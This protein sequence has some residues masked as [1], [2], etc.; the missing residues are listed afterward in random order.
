[1]EVV[2]ETPYV[3]FPFDSTV[4]PTAPALTIVVKGTFELRSGDPAVALPKAKQAPIASD[5]TYLDDLGRSLRRA[6]DLVPSK[7]R[8]EVTVNAVCHT[9]GGRPRTACDVGIAVGPIVKALR[10]TGDRV[11]TRDAHGAL[12]ASNPAPF[13][14]MPIRWERAFGGLAFPENPLGL[15]LEP[16]PDDDGRLVHALPN[17]EYVDARVERVEDRPAPA[18]FGPIAAMWQPRLRRLGTRDARWA[19]FRAPLPPKDVDPRSNNAG[20]DDQQL[21]AGYFRGDEPVVLTGLHADQP[22][23]GTALPG[24]RL[25]VFLL[26]RQP[27]GDPPRFV[28]VGMCLDTVHL[29]VEAGTM[30]LVWRRAVQV[31]SPQHPEIEAAY[32]AEERLADEPAPL[33]AHRARFEALRPPRA[34]DLV[35]ALDAEITAQLAEAKKLLADAKLP[36]AEL[37][38][39][40]GM[41][42][43]KKLLE[44]V[45]DVVRGKTAELA[46][47]T[48]T[49]KAWH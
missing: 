43:P 40:E 41:S 1:M 22:T 8:G 30:D 26:V 25:R 38:K 3:F 18:C 48:E 49:L 2:T 10:V 7:L 12:R 24:V 36:P 34:P 42:D 9:E 33:E 21:E 14:I 19:A 35:A 37:A 47:L 4:V 45:L 32:V 13:T 39:L 28:E 6:T 11:F 44:A 46:E 5:E 29:E 31:T 20:P 16:V 23:Y 17:V 27:N 15:G